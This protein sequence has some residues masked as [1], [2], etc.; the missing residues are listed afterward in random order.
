[1]AKI[2]KN[3]KNSK[4]LVRKNRENHL[5]NKDRELHGTLLVFGHL[6]L[7]LM[8]KKRQQWRL[9]VVVLYH[10]SGGLLS[11]AGKHFWTF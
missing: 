3:P 4:I 9:E 11:A 6:A 8:A 7:L 1:V 10:L 5:I 2:S